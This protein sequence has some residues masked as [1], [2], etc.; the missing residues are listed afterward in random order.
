MK[1]LSPD[2]LITTIHTHHFR[3][4]T[5]MEIHKQLRNQNCDIQ[6]WVYAFHL[7]IIAAPCCSKR[8][9]TTTASP[10]LSLMT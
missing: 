7:W 2:F 5:T 4:G 1:E 6:L 9:T 3:A 10:V 8:V